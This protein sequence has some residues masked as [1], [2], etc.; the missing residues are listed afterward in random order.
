MAK[1]KPI[2]EGMRSVIPTLAVE[3]ASEAIEF[4]KRAFGAEEVTRAPDPSGKKIWHAALRIGDSVV[5][6]ADADPQMNPVRK[7][8]I[9]LYVKDADATYQRAVEA[10]AKG[11]MPPADMFWGD[12]YGRIADRWDNEWGIATRVKD[13]TPQEMKKA[14]DQ[15]VASMKK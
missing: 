12:R 14:Q 1:V 15:F 6:I 9:W 7:A 13:L 2:P 4:Y 11:L 8:T 5:F 10:G 3:G